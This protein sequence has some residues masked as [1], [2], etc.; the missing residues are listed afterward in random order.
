MSST[1]SQ[2][3]YA[4]TNR[5]PQVIVLVWVECALAVVTVILRLWVRY[6]KRALGWDDWTMLFTLVCNSLFPSSK[7]LTSAF[8]CGAVNIHTLVFIRH[9]I[10]FTR[11]IPSPVLSHH[12]RRRHA[13]HH[14]HQLHH[15]IH[16]YIF[17]CARKTFG[18]LTSIACHWIYLYST[19]VCLVQV[20][21]HRYLD[22]GMVHYNRQLH[23]D[24][25]AM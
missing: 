8:S 20:V 13:A 17:L 15:P 6:F 2:P 19:K 5:G 18:R 24:L 16:H 22:A 10:C 3:S 12:N 9:K 7:K 4:D 25:C 1:V 23:H 14:N 11:R 21:D